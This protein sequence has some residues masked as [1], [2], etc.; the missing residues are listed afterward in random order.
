MK[1]PGGAFALLLALTVAGAPAR[2]GLVNVLNKVGATRA[3]AIGGNASALGRDASLVWL[4]PASPALLG[5]PALTLS[6]QRGL[7]G[8]SVGQLLLAAPLDQGVFTLGIMY[9]D[10]GTLSVYTPDDEILEIPVQRDFLG[11]INWSRALS[12][13]VSM[14]ATLKGIHSTLFRENAS[15]AVAGDLGVQFR[16]NDLVKL[17]AAIQNIGTRLRYLDDSVSLPAMA[18]FGAALGRRIGSRDFLLVTADAEA[19]FAGDILWGA[20]TEYQFNGLASLRAGARLAGGGEPGY[21]TLGA[22]FNLRQFRV[23]YGI[24]I[25][26]EFDNPQTVSLSMGF[27]RAVPP[28]AAPTEAPAI[29]PTPAPAAVPPPPEST[30]LPATPP[31][32]VQPTGKSN[33][34]G[35]EVIDDLNRELDE[36]LKNKT[37]K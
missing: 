11:A 17:G 29:I 20:G 3:E 27:P 21:F 7:Y 12:P 26:G 1:M 31:T 19:P 36:L 37:T 16:V 23:D 6:G 24:R 22:G 30:V 8:E 9:Y 5:D 10:G 13:S 28:V 4:N 33:G 32:T 25:G 35:H 34:D 15:S 2:A 18:R 14:G